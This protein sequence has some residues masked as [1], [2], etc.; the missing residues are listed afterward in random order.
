MEFSIIRPTIRVVI[1]L[2]WLWMVGCSLN[3]R[4]PDDVIVITATF[5]PNDPSNSQ[6]A[7]PTWIV[8][9]A[10]STPVPTQSIN[11]AVSATSRDYIVVAGDTLFGIANRFGLTVEQLLEA[12]TLVNP[13][14]LEIGQLLV[15]PTLPEVLGSDFLILPDRRL[16]RTIDS[17]AFDIGRFIATQTGIITT[18]TDEVNGRVL[19][20]AEIIEQISL[21]FSVDARVL[22]ALLEYKSRW[23]TRAT[24][25]PTE[26]EDPLGAPAFASGIARQ[27]IYLQLAWAADN[28]NR[29]YYGWMQNSLE[30]VQTRDDM[31][32]R[33][34]QTLNPATVG[35]QQVLSLV[36]E[37][38]TWQQ[39]VSPNGFQAVYRSFFGDPFTSSSDPVVP[40][41]LTQPQLA[42]PFSENETWFFT[43][44]AHGGWGS[45]SAWAAIDFAPPDDL[46]QKRTACYVSDYFVTAV[47]DGI[48]V[49]SNDG[50]VVLDLDGDNDET[51]GWSILYLHL[52][53]QDRIATGTRVRT[54]DLIGRPSCEGG[55]SNGTHLHIAR[56]YNGEWLPVSCDTCRAA[57]QRP[58]LVIGGWSVIM[59]PRQEYQGYMMNGNRRIIAE[60]GRN[61]ADNEISW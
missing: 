61:I 40:V 10:T 2:L 50:A 20:V 12:N 31:R 8:L 29:G 33:L 60:Q 22:L 45:G 41:G 7:T 48:I 15:L 37:L 6:I 43:G 44:G 27:G 47:A 21:N 34:P 1:L 32:V 28:L 9:S 13:D 46:T 58:P 39:A 54:G 18:A 16:V 38:T 35:V 19:S 55:F 25:T 36:S 53:T 59:L 14:I 49:R 56:R 23:L 57:F 42:L 51:T 4:P 3:T 26:Q 52:A 17:A 11:V 24:L 30:W 5:S